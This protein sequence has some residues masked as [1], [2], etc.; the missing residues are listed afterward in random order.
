MLL[1]AS[2]VLGLFHRRRSHDDRLDAHWHHPGG[3]LRF[4]RTNHVRGELSANLD[5]LERDRPRVMER[6][7]RP[8]GLPLRSAASDPPFEVVPIV[9]TSPSHV[10]CT[11]GRH[12][13]LHLPSTLLLHANE[14]LLDTTA[15]PELRVLLH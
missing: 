10:V 5:S 14:V 7:Q 9:Y 8:S 12:R 3:W 11:E 2:P 15:L 1:G 4:R 6:I 13:L